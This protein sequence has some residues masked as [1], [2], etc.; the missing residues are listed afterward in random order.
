MCILFI[1]VIAS[2]HMYSML[3][4]E[5]ITGPMEL[6]TWIRDRVEYKVDSLNY[7][8]SPR[9]TLESGE[10]DCEDFAIL[11]MAMSHDLWGW[12]PELQLVKIDGFPY[13]HYWCAWEGVIYDAQAGMIIE[14][15]GNP[16]NFTIIDRID[17][18]VAMWWS[19]L[20]YVKKL[21]TCFS[22]W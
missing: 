15:S 21:D 9:E 7:W 2:C 13:L 12:K 11:F 4:D 6:I 17:F 10:G 3:P 20:G 22:I 8:K 16:G 18:D 1:A 19:T 14:L 5:E